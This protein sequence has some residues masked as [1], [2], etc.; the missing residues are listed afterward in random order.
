M[1][2][3]FPSKELKA[4]DPLAHARSR[5]EDLDIKAVLPYVTGKTTH[6]VQNKRNTSKA[7]QA[8]VDGKHVVQKSYIEAIVYASTPSDLE[9]EESLCPLEED[10]DASWPDP[11]P[12]LPSRGKEPTELSD[13]AYEPNTD[14]SNVFDGYTF[15]FCDSGRFEDLQGPITSGQGKALLCDIDHAS[16]SAEDIVDYVK[17]AAGNKG[18]AHELDGSGGVILVQ[19]QGPRGHEE[20]ARNIQQMVTRL[21][22]QKLV[23]PSE[24]LDAIL[25][26][27]ASKLCQPA[28]EDEVLTE[29]QASDAGPSSR[30]Q[31]QTSQTNPQDNVDP[32]EVE[33]GTEESAS[34]NAGTA[35]SGGNQEAPRP[36][37]RSRTRAYIPKFKAFDDDFDMDSIP[38]YTL[39]QGDGEATEEATQVSTSRELRL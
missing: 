22:R 5:V 2:F 31:P 20:W 12:H 17:K 9:N 1:S 37:K 36:V 39:E 29:A 35:L 21:T 34:A 33:Q 10:F 28:Q 7:L 30:R 16:T 15:V 11:R 27:D 25:K 3:S 26:N 4:K 13:S 19:F 24:F 38:A 6:V 14:R 23:E 32:I 8:L 18:L